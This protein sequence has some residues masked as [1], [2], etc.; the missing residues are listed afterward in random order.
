MSRFDTTRWSLVLK[1][2][3]DAPDAR[4]ALE[5]L[6]R[7][8]RPPVVAYVRGRGY[9]PDVA[10]DLAQAFFAQFI[11][12]AWHAG[13]DPTRGRFR[14][15]LLTA[16]KRHL[17]DDTTAAHAQKRGGG[18]L[19]ES[20]DA[21]GSAQP[22]GDDSPERA[23][24]R[25]WALALLQ[26]AIVRLQAEAED[27]GKGALFVALREFLVEAPDE[28]DYARAAQALGLRRNTLAV[29]V[30]RLRHRLRELVQAELAQ[31]TSNENEFDEEVRAL[32][33][34]LGTAI[35]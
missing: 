8:Y 34:S 12:K 31:T 25:A 22:V 14:A 30:H 5:A 6:C 11:E 29:A 15:Y 28:A 16:L 7:L 9:P 4:A 21:D 10:D 20:L 18:Q 3:A 26:S 32:R 23:F 2:R 33:A 35:E 17:I 13:A 24:E 19:H 1:A 27:A